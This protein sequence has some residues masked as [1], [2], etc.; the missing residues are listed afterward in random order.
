M[1]PVLDCVSTCAR[2][3]A[4]IET[5]WFF[6]TRRRRRSTTCFYVQPK[7][8][9]TAFDL[10]ERVRPHW[11]VFRRA[12]VY[13]IRSVGGIVVR[14]Q[15]YVTITVVFS[16]IDFSR[17]HVVSARWFCARARIFTLLRHLGFEF[18]RLHSVGGGLIE[19]DC[20]I[21]GRTAYVMLYDMIYAYWHFNVT[22][23]VSDENASHAGVIPLTFSVV[24]VN[25]TERNNFIRKV[26][27]IVLDDSK[28]IF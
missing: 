16:S 28:H 14:V 1:Y 23:R 13:P 21:K 18:P 12:P 3:Y 27:S 25:L 5:C 17:L 10:G 24:R 11:T 7:A 19:P 8:H 20:L 9:R 15:N 26:H 22:R 6:R 4:R 2:P